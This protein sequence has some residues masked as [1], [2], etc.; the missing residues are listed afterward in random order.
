MDG[1]RMQIYGDADPGYTAT[2]DLD[3]QHYPLVSDKEPFHSSFR[4]YDVYTRNYWDGWNDATGVHW[5]PSSQMTVDYGSGGGTGWDDGTYGTGN[6][7]DYAPGEIWMGL[8]APRAF[9]VG[10][11]VVRGHFQNI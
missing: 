1:N 2:Y 4:K 10:E 11:I 9:E 5:R 8:K 3:K 6:S 7:F